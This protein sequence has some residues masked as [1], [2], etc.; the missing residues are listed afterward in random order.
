MKD[1]ITMPMTSHRAQLSLIIEREN[2]SPG[3]SARSGCINGKL[4]SVY[5]KLTLKAA[6]SRWR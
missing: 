6:E 2:I 3:L 1:V 4:L 5:E